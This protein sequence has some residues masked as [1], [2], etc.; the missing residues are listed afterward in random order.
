M[1][2]IVPDSGSYIQNGQIRSS[3]G[4]YDSANSLFKQGTWRSGKLHG[5]SCKSTDYSG[6]MVDI[7]SGPY[8]IGK[9]NGTIT[10]Y[11][12]PK[13]SWLTFIAS[14]P[15]GVAATKYVQVYTNGVLSSTT[16]T[17]SVNIK[18]DIT[19]N[20]NGYINSFTFNEV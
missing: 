4:Y 1:I 2:T 16:S 7:R 5:A 14:P 13:S 15:A 3:G 6:N 20:V 11:V 9:E 8:N 12:F 18:G 17:S 19:Y 10:E